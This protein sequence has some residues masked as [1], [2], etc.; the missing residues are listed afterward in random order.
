[1]THFYLGHLFH[2]LGNV[3]RPF[4][5]DVG[6]RWLE[7]NGEFVYD[8]LLSCDLGFVDQCGWRRLGQRWS[9][10]L[11]WVTD[12]KSPALSTYIAN[13]A[14]SSLVKCTT[15]I[16]DLSVCYQKARRWVSVPS[17]HEN[18]LTMISPFRTRSGSEAVA[19][20]LVGAPFTKVGC[21]GCG[22]TG[23]CASDSAGGVD[24]LGWEWDRVWLK[25]F[26]SCFGL[27]W[28]SG[29]W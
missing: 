16:Q 8:S 13:L 4:L 19:L 3:L 24:S 23:S 6:F 29:C 10:T 17:M 11:V 7:E 21:W 15:F 27:C 1:M 14:C 12:V 2:I 9:T 25:G 5:C 18:C 26:W 28:W 22:R 20:F